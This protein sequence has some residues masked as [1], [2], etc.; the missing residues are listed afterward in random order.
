MTHGIDIGRRLSLAEIDL[1]ARREFGFAARYYAGDDAN[2]KTL[3]T[4][5]IAALLSR[6]MGIVPVFQT[7]GN[8]SGYFSEAQGRI[9]GAA[10]RADGLRRGQP[11]GTPILFAVDFDVQA[12]DSLV[13]YFNGVYAGLDGAFD[14]GVYGEFDVVKLARESWPALVA[15]WQTYAWSRGEVYYAAD[16]FQH[17]NGVEV[18]PGLVVDLNIARAPIPWR[19]A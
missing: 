2:P 18:A 17:A 6:R 9:D 1:L 13:H 15:F 7:S 10:A 19:L 11:L 14:P 4:D 5:E 16:I 12:P 3:T 8:Y